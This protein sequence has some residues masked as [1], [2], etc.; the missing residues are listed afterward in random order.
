MIATTANLTF[1]TIDDVSRHVASCTEAADQYTGKGVWIHRCTQQEID[2]Q[3]DLISSAIEKRRDL[4]LL[5]LTF[6]VKDNIDVGG[7][8]TTAACPAYTYAPEVSSYVVDRLCRAG[9]VVLGKTNLDQFATGLVGVRSPYGICE[10]YYDHKYISGGSSSGSAVSVAAGICDFSLGTDTAGSGRVPAAFNN[11]VGLK[12]TRGL[13]SASGVVPACRSLDCVSIFARDC[14]VA[15]RVFAVAESYDETDIYSR[16]RKDIPHTRSVHADDFKIGVPDISVL[17]F[18]GNPYSEALYHK[19][20]QKLSTIGGKVTEID[21]SS[22]IE[23]SALL[24]EGPW[25][26]ERLAAIHGFY[27]EQ[28]DQVL[29]VTRSIIGSA[30]K[31][32][33]VDTFRGMYR[34][35]ALKKTSLHEW[36]KMDI[37]AVPTA[38]TIY[39]IDEVLKNPVELN[40]NLGYY[41]NYVNLL[42]LCAIALPAGFQPN[43]LPFG[44]TLIAQ[45]GHEKAL[46]EIGQTYLAGGTS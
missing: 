4:P 17:E 34:L 27:S 14:D 11:I 31:L 22:F 13:L 7:I 43:G 15:A 29:P 19:A 6:A 46:L 36:K 25:L 1:K 30:E 35:A 37:L 16:A 10:N 3:L 38:G 33:A 42:D 12:P 9:A 39:T 2:R 40:R 24:Y 21:Y 20:V 45:A 26:A 18:F 44:I 41:T 32:S 5:G 28:P 23:T 8:P